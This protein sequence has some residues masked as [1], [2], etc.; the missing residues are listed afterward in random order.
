MTFWG[1]Y[2]SLFLFLRTNLM[3]INPTDL[4]KDF[5]KSGKRLITQQSSDAL[6]AKAKEEAE[7]DDKK[8]E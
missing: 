1:T 8:E 3:G 4:S 2:G 6:L 7:K 5:I